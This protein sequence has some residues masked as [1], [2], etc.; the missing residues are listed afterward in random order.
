MNDSNLSDAPNGVSPLLAEFIEQTPFQALS[1][2]VVHEAKRSLLNFVA[3]ALSVADYPEIDATVAT[4][5]PYAAG[6]ACGLIGR[7]ERLDPLNAAF[8]NAV[9]ANL[10]DFDDTHLQTV[11]HP[12]APVAPPAFALSEVHGCSGQVLLRAFAL[13]AEIE[14]RLGNSVSPGHYARGWHI[15]ATC[16]V[17]G[18]A[19]ASG[20]L[21]G[22]D[23]NQMAH[24]LGIAASQSCGLVENLPRAAKNV[25]VGNSA[26]NGVLSALFAQRGF[27][28][29]PTAIDGRFGWARAC[30]DTPRLDAISD[31]LGSRWELLANTYKPYPCGIV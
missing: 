2:E 4:L 16:G 9:S 22:L 29:A 7:S 1:P 27:E 19:V 13:G 25:A 28:A 10:L 14:C 23:V 3:G 20:C 6:G 11:I 30:G 15:T 12:S 26:R 8:V 31:E 21:L 18:A 5:A 17:F 24:A